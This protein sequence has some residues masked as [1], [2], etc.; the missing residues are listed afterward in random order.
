M[1][2]RRSVEAGASYFFTLV[3]YERVSIFRNPVNCQHWTDAILKVQSKW[4]FEVEGEVIL[5]DHLHMIWRL[6]A[7][8]TDY[9]TRIRLVKT[10]FTKSIRLDSN[11]D[12]SPY[13]RA[14]K[15]EKEVWQRRYWEHLIRDERDFQVHLDYIHF[16]PVKHGLVKRP[17]DWAHS[18]FNSWVERGTYADG[19][20]ADEMPPLPEW[21]GK[22]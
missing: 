22:E 21:A 20:G 12:V 7:N 19:W 6:P 18:T 10:A 2:Y 14:L 1:R 17:R 8:D 5:P 9:A 16:N 3:T 13:S 15:G 4:P 11:D